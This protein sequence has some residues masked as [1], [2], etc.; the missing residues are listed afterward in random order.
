MRTLAPLL[1][2]L[3]S[4]CAPYRVMPLDALPYMSRS[5]C[6][7][8]DRIRVWRNGSAT[9]PAM[10]QFRY[11]VATVMRRYSLKAE[12]FARVSVTYTDALLECGDRDRGGCRSGELIGVTSDFVRRRTLRHELSH[13]AIDVLR[14][15]DL[16]HYD[17]DHGRDPARH[18]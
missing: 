6:Y 3:L 10:D 17:L 5:F 1:L 11:D 16:A 14:L 7:E 9:C 15:G 8:A 13:R 2:L 18:P 4:G 12:D